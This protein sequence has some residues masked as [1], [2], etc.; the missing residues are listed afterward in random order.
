MDAV[1]GEH[2][3][4]INSFCYL[5]GTL[6]CEATAERA[7]RTRIAAAWRK[8][9]EIA[10]VLINQGIPLKSRG[11]I[12]DACIRPVLEFPSETWAFTDRLS[13]TLKTCDTQMLR[14]TR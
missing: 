11:E 14:Y 9:R 2:L 3:D 8:C 5:G 10:T 1:N 7:V 12:S 4:A 6:G 13:K